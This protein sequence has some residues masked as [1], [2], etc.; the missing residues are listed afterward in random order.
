GT[1]SD[2]RG[3]E[4]DLVAAVRNRVEAGGLQARATDLTQLGRLDAT[5]G[6]DGV[7]G[8]DMAQRVANALDARDTL[9]ERPLSSVLLRLDHPEGGEDRIRIDL[10]G[11]SVS[12]TLDVRDP[13]AADRLS[14]HTPELSRALSQHGL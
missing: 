11:Q 7:P 9:A 2:D 13:I 12:T 5:V 14:A 6:K 8:S 3:A 4:R 10:R 1:S